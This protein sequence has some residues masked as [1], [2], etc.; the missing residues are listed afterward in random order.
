M[1]LPRLDASASV[2]TFTRN[3]LDQ[4]LAEIADREPDRRLAA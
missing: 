3:D 4:V 2:R 1:D